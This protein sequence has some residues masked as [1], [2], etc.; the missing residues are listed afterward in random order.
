MSRKLKVLMAPG[1]MLLISLAWAE[2]DRAKEL[3]RIQGASDPSRSPAEA[4]ARRSVAKPWT[5]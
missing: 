3:E 1:A 2:G 4:G 5:W